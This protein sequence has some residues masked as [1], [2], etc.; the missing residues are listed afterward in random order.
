MEIASILHDIFYVFSE[1]VRKTA[2]RPVGEL[3]KELLKN[4]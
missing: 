1:Q 2:G 4:V 3:E